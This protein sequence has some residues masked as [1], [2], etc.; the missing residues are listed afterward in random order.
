MSENETALGEG[1]AKANEP[2]PEASTEE[3]TY[4]AVEKDGVVTAFIPDPLVPTGALP[5]TSAAEGVAV[6]ADGVVY[7]AEVG[8]KSLKR[9]V[10]AAK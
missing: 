9:Y 6:D 1:A 5:A 3:I 2:A 10:K 8:S 4:H 7:G